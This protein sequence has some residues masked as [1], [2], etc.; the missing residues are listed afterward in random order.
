MYNLLKIDK[1]NHR[2]ERDKGHITRTR[3]MWQSN[4]RP[5]RREREEST[6]R[7]AQKKRLGERPAEDQEEPAQKQSEASSGEK[8]WGERDERQPAGSPPDPDHA[9]CPHASE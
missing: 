4:R 5:S 9:R 8:T 2:R 3:R 7:S 6:Q 1:T